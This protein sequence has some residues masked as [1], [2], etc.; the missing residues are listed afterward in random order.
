M[1]RLTRDGTA[2]PL[3]RDQIFRRDQG[4]GKIRSLPVQPTTSR[5][6]NHNRLIHTLAICDYHI[7][8]R[9]Y[10]HTY[11]QHVTTRYSKLT[12]IQIAT[13]SLLLPGPTTREPRKLIRVRTMLLC[14]WILLKLTST[15]CTGPKTCDP[16]NSPLM[17][18]VNERIG[19][20]E[21]HSLPIGLNLACYR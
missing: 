6:G 14:L 8:I 20:D 17:R 9:T 3:S 11:I 12:G 21:S 19:S 7:Y 2:E 18:W 5:I 13:K 15:V 10:I 4:Q 1:S 16:H